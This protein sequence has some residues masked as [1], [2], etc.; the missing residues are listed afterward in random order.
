MVDLEAAFE[1]L[2]AAA[3]EGRFNV[4]ARRSVLSTAQVRLH[5]LNFV[6]ITVNDQAGNGLR[7]HLWDQRFRFGQ[8]GFEI[9]DHRFD[10][11]S[12]V[13]GGE[14][15]QT[16]YQSL[17][18][19][20]GRHEAFNVDYRSDGSWLSASGRVAN[21]EVIKRETFRKGEHYHL[22][23]GVLHSLVARSRSAA[24]LVLTR[25][26]S[27]SAPITF[28]PENGPR[29]VAS[30]RLLLRDP[31]GCPLSLADHTLMEVADAA[32]VVS[33]AEGLGT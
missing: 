27:A 32:V 7:L 8:K 28:G 3:A 31:S 20:E 4:E 21:L 5:P 10:L 24:T 23:H 18:S 19:P 6:A 13:V 1:A 33:S 30:P 9:H 29:S 15:E 16:I 11:H 14:M 22:K 26:R 2:I 12:Y 17:L 25:D